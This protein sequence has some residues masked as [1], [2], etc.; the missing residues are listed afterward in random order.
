MTQYSL[1]PA[2]DESKTQE[3]LDLLF[4]FMTKR[5]ETT[6]TQLR[7]QYEAA[8]AKFVVDAKAFVRRYSRNYI[9][10][11]LGPTPDFD[12]ITEF[13]H[14]E[15]SPELIKKSVRPGPMDFP[16]IA[17]VSYLKFSQRLVV[18]SAPGYEPG[19]VWK[20][21]IFIRRATE[22]SAESVAAELA[23]FVDDMAKGLRGSIDRMMLYTPISPRCNYP[24]I[25]Y[26]T[27]TELDRSFDALVML[28]PKKDATLPETFDVPSSYRVLT[29]LDF[30]SYDSK[31]G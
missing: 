12:S 16:A 17:R 5:V 30:E 7:D 25:Y 24:T 3:R 28:W 6:P 21:G 14:V 13:A 26:P 11:V 23:E 1:E 9:V 2:G 29:V 20:R 4:S 10:R 15:G 8:T 27:E 19:P 31:I 22:A 18:G